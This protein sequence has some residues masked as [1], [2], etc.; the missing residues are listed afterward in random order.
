VKAYGEDDQAEVVVLTG[1][2]RVSTWE[3]QQ[4][5]VVLTPGQ[6]AVYL[7][8]NGGLTKSQ[9]SH[10]EDFLAWQRGELILTGTTLDQLARL[11]QRR[12]GTVVRVSGATDC[13]ITGR[14]KGAS[15]EQV[16][17]NICTLIDATYR[18]EGQTIIISGKNC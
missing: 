11:L 13:R 1:K 7:R 8:Q 3:T 12:Y 6:K 2:V 16:L 5:G 17:I 15:L 14:F 4:N 10:P 18:R 9:V